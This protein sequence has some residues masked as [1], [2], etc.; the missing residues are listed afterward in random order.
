MKLQKIRIVLSAVLILFGLFSVLVSFT[1]SVI[2]ITV[3]MGGI[4]VLD[5][6][7]W[8]MLSMAAM[9]MNYQ[10]SDIMF[11]LMLAATAFGYLFGPPAVGKRFSIAIF[12]HDKEQQSRCVG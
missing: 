10:L 7:Y 5:G 9:E 12:A 6:M 4:G 11:S 1:Q 3:Y 8:P 2:L